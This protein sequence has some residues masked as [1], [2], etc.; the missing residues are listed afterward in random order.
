MHTKFHSDLF[1]SS[2]VR[3]GQRQ[4]QGMVIAIKRCGVNSQAITVVS[5]EAITRNTRQLVVAGSKRLPT[6][7]ATH[8]AA[9]VNGKRCHVYS[10]MFNVWRRLLSAEPD[11]GCKHPGIA[12]AAILFLAASHTPQLSTQWAT[13]EGSRMQSPAVCTY[14]RLLAWS[15]CYYMLR[16]ENGRSDRRS[17]YRRPDALHLHAH[18]MQVTLDCA[19]WSA[20]ALN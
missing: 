1:P 11:A 12:G 14:C 3:T 5:E 10:V 17:Q 7:A 8:G 18:E 13:G 19:G 4:G 6:S 20:S 15:A 2:H 16:S 9:R